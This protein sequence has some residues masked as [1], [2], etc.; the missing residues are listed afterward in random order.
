MKRKTKAKWQKV[1]F[2]ADC[3]DDLCPHCKI[4]Y[5]EC[6][7]PGPTQDGY[8]YE[9]RNDGMYARLLDDATRHAIQPKRG[10]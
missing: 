9:E 3:V 4:D 8:E 1:V 6:P 7:C 10:T 2:A 5:A